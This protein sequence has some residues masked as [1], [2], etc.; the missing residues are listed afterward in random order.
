MPEEKD[1][2]LYSP[3]A[4]VMLTRGIMLDIAS[5]ICVVLI[6]AA[7]IGLIL[8]KIVYVIGLVI[9]TTW[10]FIRS[11][12]LSGVAE[13]KFSSVIQRLMKKQG[14]KIAFKAVPIAGDA[15]PIWTITIYSEITGKEIL[16]KI[17]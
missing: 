5:I 17:L 9:V 4:L 10:V 8:A 6:A 14:K 16:P 15:L 12:Q 13:D 7:G 2:S 3:Q 11:G 1:K